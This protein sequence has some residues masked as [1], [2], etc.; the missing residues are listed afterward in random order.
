MTRMPR[1]YPTWLMEDASVV[2][3]LTKIQN[4]PQ[5]KPSDGEVITKL[6]ASYI[7]DFFG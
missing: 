2:Q 7:G 5:S 6:A 1:R 3:A 4:N